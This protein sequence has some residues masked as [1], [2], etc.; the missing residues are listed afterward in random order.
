MPVVVGSVV[1]GCWMK[2]ELEYRYHTYFELLFHNLEQVGNRTNQM[3]PLLVRLVERA[4][5][6]ELLVV[7]ADFQRD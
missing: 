5:E 1:F 2:V 6:A 3:S 4:V 7:V